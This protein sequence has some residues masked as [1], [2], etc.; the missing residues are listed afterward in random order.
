[1]A[2]GPDPD[3]AL[4]AALPPE[5]RELL[6]GR[7]LRVGQAVW[8]GRPGRHLAARAGAGD[9]FRGHRP[10]VAGDDLRRLDW[11]AAARDDRYVLRQHDAEDVLSAVFLLDG[12]GGMSY[13]TG[14][15]RKST[16]AAALVAGLASLAARQGDR[17]GLASGG[18]GGVELQQARPQGGARRLLALAEALARPSAGI[19]PWPRLVAAVGPQLPRRSLVVLV[20]DFL[21]PCAEGQVAGDMSEEAG[22]PAAEAGLL[23]ELAALAGRGHA[24]VLLQVLHRDELEFPWSGRELLRLEDVRGVRPEVEG[25]GASLRAAYLQRVQ[26][27]LAAFHGGCLARGLVCHRVVTDTP[28]TAAF[29]GLLRALGGE[30]A[31]EEVRA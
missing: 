29:L 24:V 11:R 17:V 14:I 21:D 15:E 30:P 27:Y 7:V 31:P 5:L 12:S 6:R 2:S 1:M 10:Y 26:A 4:A 18:G 3:T 25:L 13:G 9:V 19:C 28:V 22:L 8:G 20:S 23:D 16:Y